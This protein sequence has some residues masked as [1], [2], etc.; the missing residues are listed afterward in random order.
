M[1]K[2]IK[3]IFLFYFLNN[4][5]YYNTL[6]LLNDSSLKQT[7]N[8]K[9]N[10]FKNKSNFNNNQQ[11]FIRTYSTSSFCN[12]ENPNIRY[13]ISN[14]KVLFYLG[15]FFEGEGSNS[16]AISVGKEF[17]YGVNI[18]PIFNVTQHKNGIE[19]LHA[20]KDLFKAGSVLKKSGSDNVWVYTIKGYKKINKLVI[21]FLEEYVQPFSCKKS[22]YFIF[23]QICYMS[24][25]GGQKNK[26]SL[27]EMV[28][29]AYEFK[30]KGNQRKRSLDEVI[31]LINNK[32]D[33]FDKE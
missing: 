25:Q 7:K 1:L 2:G 32:H 15:G 14:E 3:S 30:G 21:P 31:K 27:I 11:K 29:L 18:Q 8:L 19:I 4:K 16:V 10:N 33:Y 24:E 22:E 13:D 23:K 6:I 5:N 9:F 20:F 17:K 26:E 12:I 28:T